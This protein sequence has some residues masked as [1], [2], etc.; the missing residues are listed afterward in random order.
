MALA[1]RLIIT[2]ASTS[3]PEPDSSRLMPVSRAYLVTE[4]RVHGRIGPRGKLE[5]LRE[6]LI[7]VQDLDVDGRRP[8]GGSDQILGPFG[9]TSNRR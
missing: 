7:D 6:E 8:V 5:I 1:G 9:G 4:P 3:R 2:I